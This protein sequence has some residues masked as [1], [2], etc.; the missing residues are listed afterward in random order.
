V[1]IQPPINDPPIDA[2]VVPEG[3]MV[4]NRL[5]GVV[6]GGRCGVG[7]GL[8]AINY[9]IAGV[10]GTIAKGVYVHID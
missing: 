1:R 5:I 6:V 10:S 7:K 9:S 2:A 3:D 4:N 8:H